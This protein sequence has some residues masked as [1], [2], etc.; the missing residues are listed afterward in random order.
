MMQSET[1]GA[2]AKALAEAQAEMTN[3]VKK[4]TAKVGQYS[5]NYA[6]IA[7]VLDTVRPTL[8]KHGIALT[9]PTIL[10][11]D[12]LIVQTRLTHASGEFMAS[13][14]PVCRINGDHQKMGAAMTYA[15]RYSLCSM[16]GVAADDDT[17]GQ[18]A[19]DVE[20]PK[21]KS[22]AALKREAVWPKLEHELSE[23]KSVVAVDRLQRDYQ[24]N[25]YRAW[26]NRTFEEQAN[27]LFD[28]KRQEF[29]EAQVQPTG[30]KEQLVASLDRPEYL[31]YCFEMAIG[32]TDRDEANKWWAEQAAARKR[33]RLTPAEESDIRARIKARLEEPQPTL[34]R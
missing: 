19:S 15:R 18:G 31:N 2:I 6:D 25:E 30:L 14:Y 26:N 7:E 21:R 8:A 33:Y 13:D 22:S 1:I 9:Q 28:K 24:A 32:F 5:Y 16:I 34:A 11:E 29:Y 23:C 12:I 10:A 20:A 27:E 4:K 3:P 17:D